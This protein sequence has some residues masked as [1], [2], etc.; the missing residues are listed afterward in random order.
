VQYAVK[1]NISIEFLRDINGT[2]GFDIKW[3]RHFK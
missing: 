1:K 3:V 2:Y